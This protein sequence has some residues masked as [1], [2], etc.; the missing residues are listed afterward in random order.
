LAIEACQL[1]IRNFKLEMIVDTV[2]SICRAFPDTTEDIKWGSDLV[3]SVGGKMYAVVCLDPPHT[4]AFKC[5]PEEFAEL[6][7][8]EGI[9]PAPYLARA[10]W[11]QDQRLGDGLDRPELERLIGTSYDLV[12]AKLPKKRTTKSRARSRSRRTSSSRIARPR[13]RRR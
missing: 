10:M 11:V 3:F 1:T 4:I 7:E 8:R 12:I 2:R 6:I 9:R 13:T 5:T